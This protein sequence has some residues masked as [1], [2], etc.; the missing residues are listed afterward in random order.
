MSNGV[1]LVAQDMKIGMPKFARP[2]EGLRMEKRAM[3]AASGRNHRHNGVCPLKV[4][5][6]RP[7]EI[8]ASGAHARKCS[9]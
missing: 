4:A 2:S 5:D 6:F 7:E 1:L 3:P 9:V 8:I